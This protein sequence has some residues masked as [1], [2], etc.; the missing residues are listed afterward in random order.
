MAHNP[1]LAPLPPL[2]LLS[3]LVR[4]QNMEDLAAD[5]NM[6]HLIQWV[7]ELVPD[8]ALLNMLKVVGSG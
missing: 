6:T 7:R 4:K 5:L 3:P 2:G 8:D 1:S